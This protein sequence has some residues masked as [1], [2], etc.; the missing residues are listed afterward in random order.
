MRSR[1]LTKKRR[2]EILPKANEL[3]NQSVPIK[4][5]LAR[6]RI[7]YRQLLS[8]SKSK[9]WIPTLIFKQGYKTSKV[10]RPHAYVELLR[11]F[12]SRQ[13]KCKDLTIPMMAW[14]FDRNERTIR[15]WIHD[16]K[17][18]QHTEK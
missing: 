15:R 6:L 5:I 8:L 9:E 18:Q 3:V 2:Q 1:T 7:T 16:K 11:E 4:Q 12:V 17:T 14:M 10:W 13:S